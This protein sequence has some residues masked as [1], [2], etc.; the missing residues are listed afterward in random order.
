[1]SRLPHI[2]KK[3]ALRA[4]GLFLMAVRKAWGW[5]REDLAEKAGFSQ[6]TI[7]RIEAGLQEP[8]LLTLCALAVALEVPVCVLTHCPYCSQ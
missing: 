7:W 8:G 3:Q 1:M 2:D 6:L 5:S 4:F